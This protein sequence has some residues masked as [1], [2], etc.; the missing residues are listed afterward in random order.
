MGNDNE[1]TKLR[2]SETRSDE[3]GGKTWKEQ[4]EG[5]LLDEF[6]YSKASPTCV[7]CFCLVPLI[8]VSSEESKLLP[9]SSLALS[10]QTYL[11]L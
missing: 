10:I 2:D 3:S 9:S 1:V 8:P 11:L 7:P 6:I 5:D 4:G